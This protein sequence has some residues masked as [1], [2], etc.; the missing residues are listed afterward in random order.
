MYVV[1]VVDNTDETMMD[2]RA[3]AVVG[4]ANLTDRVEFEFALFS[5]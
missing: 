1:V 5:H 3:G 2:G 4:F